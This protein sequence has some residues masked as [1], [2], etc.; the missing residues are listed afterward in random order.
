LVGCQP[1][2]KSEQGKLLIEQINE[3]VNKKFHISSVDV[4]EA[5]EAAAARELNIGN[6]PVEP[7]TFGQFLSV[8]IFGKILSAYRDF[9]KQEPRAYIQHYGSELERPHTPITPAEAWELVERWYKEDEQFA[10]LAPYQLAYK[11]LVE[12]KQMKPV[13]P[14]KK[15]YGGF[16]LQ[17][18]ERRA[19]EQFMKTK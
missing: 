2:P 5:F 9:K 8:A 17:Y 4:I 13:V 1:F 18:P 14:I 6:K 19:V 12:T 11:H 15:G 7:D 10:Y 16:A 3:F